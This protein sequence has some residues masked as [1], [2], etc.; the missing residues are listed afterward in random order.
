MKTELL[1]GK[2]ASEV[3]DIWMTY[4]EGKDNTHGII[5][6]G[7]ESADV[8][9]H[10]KECPFFV[11]P[12]FRDEGY[13]MLVSQFQEPSHFLMAYLE[14]YKMDPARA[15]PL[16]TF[17]VFDDL[18]KKLDLGLV[19]CDILNKGVE[20]NEGRK[21]VNNMLDAYKKDEEFFKVRAFNQAPDSFDV[22]DYIS[23]QNQK[24]KQEE[25]EEATS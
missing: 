16:L 11:Q 14:D 9:K 7:K 19:R 18:S 2:S 21:V 6:S 24:W 17:S 22:D 23:C 5:M 20:D 3:S 4:H 25:G 10:A 15:Q 8:L 13:F 12:I 1:E